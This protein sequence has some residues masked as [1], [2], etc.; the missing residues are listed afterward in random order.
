MG[1]PEEFQTGE[2][3]VLSFNNTYDFEKTNYHVPA[4]AGWDCGINLVQAPISRR[5]QDGKREGDKIWS[6]V[7]LHGTQAARGIS[8]LGS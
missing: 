2:S 4:L 6:P 3:D 7:G 5:I 1:N 8:P